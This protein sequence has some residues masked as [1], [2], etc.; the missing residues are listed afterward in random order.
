MAGGFF[1]SYLEASTIHGLRYLN[2]NTRLRDR[3]FWFVVIVVQFTVAGYWVA[4][5]L[6]F[7]SDNPIVRSFE[8]FLKLRISDISLLLY[9]SSLVNQH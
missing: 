4:N 9:R 7:W 5:S 8:T 6:K 2:S 3:F 1:A